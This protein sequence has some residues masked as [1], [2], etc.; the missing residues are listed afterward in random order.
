MCTLTGNVGIPFP[1]T[2]CYRCECRSTSAKKALR[3]YLGSPSGL[4]LTLERPALLHAAFSSLPL[5]LGVLC[6]HV[7]VFK[8]VTN[9]SCIQAAA[10]ESIYTPQ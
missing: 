9:A 4:I 6:L 7:N 2:L 1:R 8:T 10:H 3:K 5:P